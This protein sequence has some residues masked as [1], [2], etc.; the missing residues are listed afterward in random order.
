MNPIGV[1][2]MSYARPFTAAHFPL[3]ARMKA[4]G[5]DFC[6]LLVPEPGELHPA[7]VRRAAGDAGLFLQLAARVNLQRDLS[8]D[9]AAARRAG[10]DY[11]RRCIDV[12]VECG[13]TIVGGPLYGSPLV[14]AGRP[15]APINEV[16][17]RERVKRV[18]EGLREVAEHAKGTD[19][20][21]AVEPLNRFETDFCNTTQQAVAL[22]S[23]VD[24]RSVGIMLDTFHMNMEE[25][26]LP[27]AIRLAGPLL[28][29][30]Q[31]NENHRGFLGTGH[32][33]WPGICRALADVDYTGVI[34][35]EPFRRRGHLLS[36][37]LAQWRPPTH[38]EDADL[39]ASGDLLRGALHAARRE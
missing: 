4:A 23:L 8:S 13:A 20:R 34:T 31:A 32:L 7:E 5:M 24:H 6:E 36:M 27:Q 26:D 15:P 33:D 14:F 16:Q 38:D 35:L 39:Q 29:H 11:L 18:T 22:C 19:M 17:R 21:F 2:S 28:I 37:P 3:F 1:I 25:D 12:A 10:V 30:F 9:D